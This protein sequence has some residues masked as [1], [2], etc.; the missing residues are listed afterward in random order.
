M[1]KAKFTLNIFGVRI[2]EC[3]ASCVWKD[4][5]RLQTRRRCTKLRKDVSPC[6]CCKRWDMNRQMM[7]VHKSVGQI[8]RREYQLYLLKIRE[9]ETRNEVKVER[10]IEDI[11]AEFESQYGS[12]YINF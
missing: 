8:K 10:R 12:I 3:C 9:E 5:T 6:D 1:K 11:R 4:A 2:K 7:E